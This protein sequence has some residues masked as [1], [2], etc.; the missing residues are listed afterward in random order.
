MLGGAGDR[1]DVNLAAQ[2][3]L[4]FERDLGKVL[5]QGADV[6]LLREHDYAR[7]PFDVS[8]NVVELLDVELTHVTVT[9]VEHQAVL[10]ATEA[11]D[12]HVDF[13]CVRCASSTRTASERLV[14]I[15]G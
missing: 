2:L 11:D 4:L 1:G 3:R 12:R 6:R 9:I 15:V 10:V 14:A 8:A 13:P 5:A 7:V